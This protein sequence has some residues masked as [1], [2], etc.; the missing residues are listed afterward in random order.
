MAKRRRRQDDRKINKK[1]KH[2][3]RRQRYKDKKDK[4]EEKYKKEE[5]EKTHYKE[6]TSTIERRPGK[7]R[8]TKRRDISVIIVAIICIVSV[9]GGYLFYNYYNDIFNPESSSQ[10]N[11]DIIPTPQPNNN[12]NNDGNDDFYNVPSFS[13]LYPTNPIVVMEIREY[14]LIVI[15]LYEHVEEIHDTVQ[16]FLQYVQMNFHDNLIFHRVIDG[17]MIQTGGFD[18]EMNEKPPPFPPIPLQIA[19]QLKHVDGAVAMARTNVPDS[20]TS[21]FYICDGPQSGLDGS[22]AVFG[23]VIAGMDIVRKISNVDFHKEKGHENVP[24]NDVIINRVYRYTGP[25]L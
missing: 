24:V 15:E 16:N 12:N 17:F 7:S 5:K 6:K 10:D 3:R 23:Q 18:T 19:D 13:P 8:D 20:A 9:I 2:A 22:Y 4:K 21:Q 14:G 1:D 11:N 25:I